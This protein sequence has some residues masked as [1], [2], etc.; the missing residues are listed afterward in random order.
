MPAPKQSW[1]NSA[2]INGVPGHVNH[3]ILT[4]ILR[5]ELGFKGFVVSDWADIKKLV[6]DWRVAANEKEA[7]KMAIMAGIDMS[8]VPLD[9]SFADILIGLVKEGA[10]PQSRIDEAVRRILRVK[11]ELGLFDKPMP[12]ATLK[13]RLGSMEARQTSLQ[14]AQ[15]SM[16]LLK[17]E[18]NLLPLSK[19]KKVLVTGPTADSLISLNNGWSYVWQG[20]EESL[21]PKDR[22]TIRRAVEAKVGPGNVTYVP[23]H[24]LADARDR[25]PMAHP[26]ASRLK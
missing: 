15:E 4:D 20:S 5:D 7:T 2:D 18:N 1:S 21:Y 12:D 17:N 8:M 10:V 24:K 13:S 23:E 19:T 22:L 26:Q 9:Y 11:F 16:T 14:A 25:P 3:H 6:S